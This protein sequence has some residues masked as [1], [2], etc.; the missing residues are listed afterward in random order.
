LGVAFEFERA[1]V[2]P[3]LFRASLFAFVLLLTPAAAQAPMPYGFWS[4][5][6]GNEMLYVGQNGCKFQAFNAQRQTTG[7]SSGQ[8]SWNPTSRGGI[9]TIVAVQVV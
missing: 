9:L 4:T 6:S 1:K 5:G 7:L 3:G 2:M 8:C